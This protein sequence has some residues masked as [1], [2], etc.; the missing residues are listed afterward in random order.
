MLH[1]LRTHEN[2]ITIL[3][4]R[5]NEQ[6]TPQDLNELERILIAQGEITE[7]EITR[8]RD[9]GGLG[10]FVRALIGMEAAV[11]QSLFAEFLSNQNLNANQIQFVQLIIR[12]LTEKGVMEAQRL[13]ESPFTD[14]ND[15]GIS[16]LFDQDTVQHIVAVLDSVRGRAAA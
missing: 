3:K 11:V 12:H 4:L 5:R 14:L 15:Q 10:V 16:G 2:H 6:L 1:F 13:Y 9:I 7:L 8:A